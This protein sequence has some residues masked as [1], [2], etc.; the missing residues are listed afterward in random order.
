[1]HTLVMVLGINFG[2]LGVGL[3]L[4][5]IF[6]LVAPSQE[7]ID[8][9][10][11]ALEKM[12]AKGWLRAQLFAFRQISTARGR[13]FETMATHWPERPQSRKLIYSGAACLAVG[14]IVGYFLG[15]FA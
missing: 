11:R 8:A 4:G 12:R 7:E 2:V 3:L 5:G 1:M 14:V 13:A 9:N 6:S 10:R 15:A